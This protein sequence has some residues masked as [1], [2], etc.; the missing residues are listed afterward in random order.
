MPSFGRL[1]RQRLDTCHE[2]L[3]YI[4]EEAIKVIDFTVVCGHRGK[5]EQ[6]KAF[7]VGNSKLQY[8]NSKHNKVPSL[9]VD[10]A[11]Y[12]TLWS[13]PRQF[14]IL[15]GVIFAIADANRIRL[16]WGGDWD[17]DWDL[18]DQKWDDLAHFEIKDR[19]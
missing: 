10:L 17:G 5:V 8:P 4:C 1:S 18:R 16:R 15:A 9:A 12:P 2:D 7:K 19:R 14:Y 13:E 3:Q 11:P 6:D